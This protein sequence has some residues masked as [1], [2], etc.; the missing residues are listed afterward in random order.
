LCSTVKQK[1]ALEYI[2]KVYRR[3]RG[4]ASLMLNLGTR[5]SWMISLWPQSLYPGRKRA[6][7]PLNRRLGG[8]QSRPQQFGLGYTNY[9]GWST[10][11]YV[12]YCMCTKIMLLD[13]NHHYHM[14]ILYCFEILSQ[15]TCLT[16]YCHFL[17]STAYDVTCKTWN[18]VILSPLQSCKSLILMT[19][20]L[21]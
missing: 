16:Y 9:D 21:H 8:P 6:Q 3:S 2:M 7:H 10:K 1:A 5:W 12:K 18:S 13:D 20:I 14:D 15:L 17:H 11:N 19:K 4:T